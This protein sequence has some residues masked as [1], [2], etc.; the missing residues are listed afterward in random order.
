LKTKNIKYLSTD[1]TLINN[2]S[3]E[4][5]TKHIPINKNRKC[6]KISTISDDVGS[7]LLCTISEGNNADAK[8]AIDDLDKLS[9]SRIIQ[10]AIEK[11][12]GNV[13]FLGDKGYDSSKI[14]KKAADMNMKCI[15][16][17][18]NRHVKNRKKIRRLS[19]KQKKIYKKRIKIE[20]FFGIIKRTAKI[21]SIYERKIRSYNGL[22]LMLFGSI[23]LNRID[24]R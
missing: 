22:L 17:P 11:T 15:I 10:K 2:K 6:I 23:L 21:N 19:R 9:N 5:L 13:Y 18:I 14:R 8:I 4:E 7:P 3:C 12:N 20:H 1:S 16:A 24:E